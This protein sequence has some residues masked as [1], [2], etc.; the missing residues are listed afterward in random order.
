V[1]TKAQKMLLYTVCFTK[2]G[3]EPKDN[4][5]ISM[6]FMWLKFV[7]AFGCVNQ[8]DQICVLVDPET[9]KYIET[10][11]AVSV[12]ALP[13][14]LIEFEQP[15]TIQEGAAFRYRI[16][17]SGLVQPTT[18][19]C[20]MDVD[21][22][23]IKDIH[24]IQAELEAAPNS[25]LVYPEYTLRHFT[26][27]GDLTEEDMIFFEE[28]PELYTTHPGMTS[29]IF[30]FR[31][32]IM[33]EPFE[34]LLGKMRASTEAHYTLDQPFFNRMVLWHCYKKQ[35]FEISFLQKKSIAY[36]ELRQRCPEE[37]K[38]I[39]FCGE[40][41]DQEFHWTKMFMALLAEVT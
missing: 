19:V 5:Y 17:E 1:P 9:K 2:K 16:Y 28:F 23:V 22:L 12:I 6:F 36:N 31:G 33:K 20:Y 7:E 27:L 29:T 34:E 13:Y 18:D 35:T 8:S 14:T 37:T 25:L 21:M 3:Q 30:G 32:G 26:Y 41:G 24:W 40:P 38:M 11:K 15:S 10:M 39:N 4:K